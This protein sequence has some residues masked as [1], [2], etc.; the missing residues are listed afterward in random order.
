VAGLL[1]APLHLVQRGLA[2]PPVRLGR[3]I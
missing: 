3:P 1:D 2:S